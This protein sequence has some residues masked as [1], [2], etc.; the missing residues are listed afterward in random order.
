MYIQRHSNWQLV[1]Y[2]IIVMILLCEFALFLFVF[3]SFASHAI[4]LK[5]IVDTDGA[6]RE[7]SIANCVFL[8]DGFQ[9]NLQH[10][11]NLL[12]L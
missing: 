1:N 10:S 8:F 7:I 12:Q 6:A 9:L 5:L 3:F 11:H 4:Q 2:F